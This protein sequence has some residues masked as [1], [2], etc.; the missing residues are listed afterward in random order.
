MN[1]LLDTNVCIALINGKPDIVRA[2]FERVLSLESTI[3]VPSIVVFELRYG[4]AKSLRR[5]SNQE[6]LGAFLRGPVDTLP[7]G[8][9]DAAE[10]GEIRADL[11]R[12]GTPIGAYDV[13]LAGQARYR[14]WTLVTANVREFARVP[15]LL[16][17]D[18]AIKSA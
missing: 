17:E 1:Y 16:W 3:W 5:E 4:A 2:R 12:L 11:E 8:D 6:R 13:L 7:F 10:A 18:W 15:A 9:E 14:G